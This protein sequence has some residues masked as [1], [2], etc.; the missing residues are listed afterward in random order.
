MM[1]LSGVRNSWLMVARK[2]LLA[3]LARSA[4]ARASSS[5]SSCSLRA[6]MSRMTATT[7]RSAIS[8]PTAWSNARQRIST[9]MYAT[10]GERVGRIARRRNSTDRLSPSDAESASA[11]R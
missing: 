11:V 5:A 8:S 4:S 2:R 7:S 6:V 3:A 9:Q 10:D 1:A